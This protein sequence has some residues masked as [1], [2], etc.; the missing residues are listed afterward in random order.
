MANAI[1]NALIGVVDAAFYV[2][3]GY[4]LCWWLN[5]RQRM[6]STPSASHN[7][8]STQSSQKQWLPV[9]SSFNPNIDHPDIG[10]FVKR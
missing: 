4:L 9:G 8:Q 10:Y 2:V 7:K 5:R 3:I 6:V 1:C